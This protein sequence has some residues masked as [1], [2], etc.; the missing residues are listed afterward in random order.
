MPGG[1]QELS[2]FGT[3]T[4]RLQLFDFD[5]SLTKT[6]VTFW[7]GCIGGAFLS[8]ATHGADHMMVQRYLC[9]RSQ[10]SAGWALASSG[11]VVFLQFAFFLFIGVALAWFFSHNPPPTP[12]AKGDQALVTFVVNHTGTGL[13]GLVLAAVFSAS[14]SSSLNSVT[15]SLMSDWLAGPVSQNERPAV[16]TSGADLDALFRRGAGAPWRSSRTRFDMTNAIVDA[17]LS[18]AGFSTG[19]ILGLY[20]L[21]LIAPNG[22]RRRVALVAFAAGYN[23]DVRCVW[24]QFG[25]R[26]TLHWLWYTLVGSGTIVIVGLALSSAV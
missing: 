9:A 25:T 6:N 20:F 14:M 17:V 21:G 16:V 26:R 8:L 22:R 3:S 24:T 23:R 15:S 2:Q 4:G 11:F 7:S 12:I 19:L 18:I 13:R 5:P 10:A 1:W